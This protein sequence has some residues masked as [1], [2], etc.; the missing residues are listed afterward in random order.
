MVAA[1]RIRIRRELR[2]FRRAIKKL[3]KKTLKK[4]VGLFAQRLRIPEGLP[5]T[6]ELRRTC[7]SLKG[8]LSIS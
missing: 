2:V 8:R 3:M 5:Q 7:N 6:N 4:A 1:Q